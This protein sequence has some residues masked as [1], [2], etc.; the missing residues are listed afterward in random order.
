MAARGTSGDYSQKSYT[1][2]PVADNVSQGR[3]HQ[4]TFKEPPSSSHSRNHERQEVAQILGVV[5]IIRTGV[6]DP[7]P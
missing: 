3:F 4:N 2:T 6:V 5:N 1:N 7:P